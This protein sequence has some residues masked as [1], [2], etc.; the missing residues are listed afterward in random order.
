MRW[1]T[2]VKFAAFVISAVLVCAPAAYAC[3]L[4]FASSSPGVLHA[5]LVSAFFMIALAWGVIGA[6]TLYAFRV[7][8]EKS[9]QGDTSTY[10]EATRS[11]KSPNAPFE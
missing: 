9:E 8:S 11:N 7:Y 3:P 1:F 6:I 2:S 4:C 10:L 5:Y